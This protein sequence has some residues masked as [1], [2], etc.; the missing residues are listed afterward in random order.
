MICY[1]LMHYSCQADRP[2]NTQHKYSSVQAHVSKIDLNQLAHVGTE[3]CLAI[4][5]CTRVSV[6]ILNMFYVL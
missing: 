2:S 4:L 5:V 6:A 1:I 3:I